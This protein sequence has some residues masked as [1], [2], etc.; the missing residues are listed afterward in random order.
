MKVVYLWRNGQAVLVHKNEEGEYVYPDEKWTED[1]PPQGIYAPFYY[2]GKKWIG[3]SKEDFEKKLQN[4]EPNERDL[5]IAT[6]SETVLGQQEEITN[7]KKDVANIMEMLIK[8]GGMT[9]V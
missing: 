9:N 2:D 3:Q 4:V 7:L 1:K 6:L 8:D 5:I